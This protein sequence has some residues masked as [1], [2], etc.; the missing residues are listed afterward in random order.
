MKRKA[1]QLASVASMIDQFTIPNIKLLHSLG[2]KVDVVA[3]FTDPGTITKEKALELKK[4]L[5]D[6]GVS[7]Y[8]VEIPRS[9]NPHAI[10]SAFSKVKEILNRE[11]YCLMHCHS[12]I[13]GAI[14]RS[15][16]IARRRK[17]LRVIYTAHGF[18]FY[19][20]APFKNWAIYYP[21]ERLLS[22][23]TDI[24]I[25]INK[26][27]YKR[28]KESFNAKIVAYIPG[29]GIDTKKFRPSGSKRKEI[30][31]ELGLLDENYML[32]SVGELNQNK[33]HESVIKAI[34]GLNITY[35]IVGKGELETHLKQVAEEYKVELRLMGFRTDVASF[36][37]AAD[38]FILPSFREGLNV[39][40][41]EAMASGL[42]CL[43]S[44]IR[45]NV[46]LIDAKG[47]Y[48]FNP[49]EQKEIREAIEKAQANS[50]GMGDYNQRKIRDF[51]L[52][53]VNNRMLEIY[54]NITGE[55]H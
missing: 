18:H 37:D 11:D 9:I 1:L 34:K 41:M 15:A 52:D 30:R 33:N 38:W 31:N 10:I 45:G 25:T 32:L 16:A 50:A 4:T 20:G 53:S 40:L 46:D 14:A 5:D 28:A 2:F 12:P 13:G 44:N 8:D 26:E 21:V 22:H 43:C 6:M 36:Y 54:Q 42:P 48:L 7:V 27:D 47:G 55:L 29:I 51:D 35:V 39:S 49:K 3:N 19:K 24:L 17:G 23:F